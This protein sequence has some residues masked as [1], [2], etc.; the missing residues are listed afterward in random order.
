MQSSCEQEL[1]DV[2]MSRGSLN[3]T[4][5]EKRDWQLEAEGAIWFLL[6]ST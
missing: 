1:G 5:E 2:S 4:A 3:G 6:L